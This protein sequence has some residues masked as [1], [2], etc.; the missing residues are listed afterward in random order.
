M[1]ER[2]PVRRSGSGGEKS[3]L[4]TLELAAELRVVVGGG[5]GEFELVCLA[6]EVGGGVDDDCGGG[7]DDGGSEFPGGVGCLA[8][9]GDDED[10]G[11]DVEGGGGR[12]GF[13][14]R[15]RSEGAI[16]VRGAERANTA[17]ILSFPKSEFF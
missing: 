1:D 14:A 5:G 9:R 17:N 3:R 2:A 11:E 15:Y 13:V 10:D 12:G 6:F 4:G 7:G 8:W 16:A